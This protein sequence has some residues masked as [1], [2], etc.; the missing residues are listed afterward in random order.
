MFEFLKNVKMS[1][2]PT[3]AVR[4]KTVG[5]DKNPSDDFLGFRVHRNGSIFPSTSLVEK[6]ALEYLPVVYRDTPTDKVDE[7]D[8]VIM[9]RE[10]IYSDKESFGFDVIDSNEWLQYPKDAPRILCVGVVNK[11]DKKV[12]IF[13]QTRYDETGE[14]TTSILEQGSKTFGIETMVPL[15]EEF[16]GIT[17]S[18]EIPYVDVE[19]VT[20]YNLGGMVRNGISFIPKTV[21]RGAN[22]GDVSYERRE[23]IAIHP[24]NIVNPFA[25][26]P[27]ET[28][29]VVEDTTEENA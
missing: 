9:K 24:L 27:E 17:L 1:E 6:F 7:A 29:V 21:A 26:V 16:A 11:T 14:P 10:T 5:A 19:V 12:S 28:E 4:V 20:E 13:A 2:G 18:E 25:V 22:K 23:Q 3:A 8:Q 15:I